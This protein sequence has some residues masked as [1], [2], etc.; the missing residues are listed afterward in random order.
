MLAESSDTTH[1][2]DGSMSLDSSMTIY[3]QEL[4]VFLGYANLELMTYLA[5]WFDCKDRWRYETKTQGVDHITGVWVNLIGATT[6]ELLQSSIPDN[7]IGGGLASRMVFVF[8]S[9]KGKIV[10]APFLTD[11][12]KRLEEVL[13]RDLE[14]ISTIY[15]EYKV[16]EEW[17]ESYTEWYLK[18]EQFPVFTDSTLVGYNSRR[19]VHMKKLSMILNAARGGGMLLAQEDFSSAVGLLERT[20]IGMPG[21]FAGVGKSRSAPVIAQAIACIEERKQISFSELMRMFSRDVDKT[22]LMRVIDTMV[23]MKL[24]KRERVG[25]DIVITFVG[26]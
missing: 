24:C 13:H 9:R 14:E 3:S 1:F 6:P 20:E 4:T 5:D 18:S 19:Q 7:L 10:P 8:E 21:T 16:T 2:P 11:S 12:D 26:R 25:E 15:G 17:M 23:A 22:E